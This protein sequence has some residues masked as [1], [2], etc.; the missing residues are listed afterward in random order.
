MTKEEAVAKIAE[1][2]KEISVEQVKRWEDQ[3]YDL[4]LCENA[5]KSNSV[6]IIESLE[7]AII[8]IIIAVWLLGLAFIIWYFS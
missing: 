4:R 1:C 7:V 8:T 2:M 6:Q 5:L 3:D